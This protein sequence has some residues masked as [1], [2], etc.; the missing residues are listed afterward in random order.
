VSN[1]EDVHHLVG[2]TKITTIN[3]SN[4]FFQMMLHA[5]SQ[6]LTA[7]YSEAHG[8][9][10]CFK[11][12]PQGLRNSP[13]HLKLLMD[14]LFGDMANEVIHYADDILI[15]TSGSVAHHL[16]IV[17]KVLQRLI[18]GNIKIRPTKV[19]LCRE[20]MEF[21]GMFGPKEKFLSLMENY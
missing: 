2:A 17:E 7:F 4:A 5:D 3:L 8:K 19:N 13:L 15:A 18:K 21:L 11:R 16:K 9:R 1:P 12:C 10:Y 14:K 6:P 20:N